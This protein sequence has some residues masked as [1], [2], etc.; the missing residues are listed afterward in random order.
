MPH[1]LSV[2]YIE[3]M[4]SFALRRQMTDA[5]YADKVKTEDKRDVVAVLHLIII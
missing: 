4:G 3:P 5:L 2:R 1:K